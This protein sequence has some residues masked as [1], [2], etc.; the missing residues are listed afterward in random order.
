MAYQSVLL[1]LSGEAL[2]AGGGKAL[3]ADAIDVI[4]GQIREVVKTGARMAVVVGGGNILRGAEI[5]DTVSVRATADQMGMLATMI[6]GLALMDGL[7]RND[8]DARLMSAVSAHQICEPFIRRRALRHQDKGRVIVLAGG[9]GNPFFTTDTTAAL[10]AS[11]LG[12]DVMLKGTKVD[13]VYDKDPVKHSDA[14]RFTTLSYAEVLEKNLRVM[15]LTA[16][17]MCM[18][19]ALPICVFD[20][21]KEGNLGRVVAGEHIGTTVVAR[22]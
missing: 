21:M 3:R 1:K 15:D 6:N 9:T 4:A 14:Q 22:S 16:I 19:N 10:R 17:T 11:E 18:D 12:C 7:E 20:V 5:S 8:C 2:G 13:G